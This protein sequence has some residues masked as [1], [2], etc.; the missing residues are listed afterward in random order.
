M[1][2]QS[3]ETPESERAASGEPGDGGAAGKSA[4]TQTT[5]QPDG[6][7]AVKPGGPAKTDDGAGA[8]DVDELEE[9]LLALEGKPK[10]PAAG[11]EGSKPEATEE[12]E[13]TPETL[14]AEIEASAQDPKERLE[15]LLK[16][17]GG[18]A[19]NLGTER[20]TRKTVEAERDGYKQAFD[21]VA[22]LYEF[23]AAGK[24]IKG[25]N[26]DNLAK[27]L[28]RF[29]L[30]AVAKG[31]RQ[32]AAKSGAKY[33]SDLINEVAA[34][35]LGFEG[36]ELKQMSDEDKLSEIS[37]N[38][39]AAL[40]L[41]DRQK[42][43]TETGQKQAADVQAKFQQEMQVAAAA[44]AQQVPHFKELQPVMEEVYA[45]LQQDQSGKRLVQTLHELAEFRRLRNGGLRGLVD[46]AKTSERAKILKSLSVLGLKPADMEAVLAGKKPEA[47]ASPSNGGDN[48]IGS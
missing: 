4:T 1:E 32:V 48:W 12:V 41:R 30:E 20:K 37:Q 8:G 42:A 19:N 15:N 28:D 5:T 7:E 26:R 16:K 22:G 36:E 35:L 9:Q 13:I 24:E 14:R 2:G 29:G 27:V 44:L 34:T 46:K 38:L 23:D 43:R 6:T 21:Q 3:F 39:D 47:G 18:M 31:Q 17:V 25:L 40:E 11:T 33:D 45:E 10:G